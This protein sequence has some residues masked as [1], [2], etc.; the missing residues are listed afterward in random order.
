[1][2]KLAWNC[3][4]R[5][6]VVL[7]MACCML[8]LP[9]FA[10]A[11]I[12]V[13]GSTPNNVTVEPGATIP[14]TVQVLLTDNTNWNSTDWKISTGL[15]TGTY[16][17]VNTPDFTNNGTYTNSLNLTAPTAAGT[18]NI[19]FRASYTIF[20]T[21]LFSGDSEPFQGGT[22]T[23]PDVSVVSIN[24]AASSPTA[25][26]TV[27]WTVTF[28]RAVTGVDAAD[29]ALANTGMTGASIASVTGSGTTWTVT[30]NSGNG[31]GTLGLNLTDDDSI[32]DTSASANRLGGTGP[33]NGNFTGQIYTIERTPPT[34]VSIVRNDANPTAAPNVTWTV[35][36]SESVTGVNTTDFILAN[37]GLTNPTVSS[38]TGS[39]TTWTV[40]ASTGTGSGTLGLNLRD[41]DS[42]VDSFGNP[43]GGTN[44]NNGNFTGQVYT[45]DRAAPAVVSI[46]RNDANPTGAASVA[47]TVNFNESVTGVDE[48][49]FALAITGLASPA[50]TN[51]TVA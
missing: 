48:A 49:D 38:A 6:F 43:L 24:R 12:S 41:D 29:F 39:G 19:Y 4:E 28:N 21:C 32:R 47:W 44:I 5:F 46:L 23:V 13:V 18:Y 33:G 22:V 50:I 11:A 31:S 36:F 8:L 27:S 14:A 45:V 9:H 7:A 30:A 35:T 3:L 16:A 1:M 10:H 42:I 15:N 17:C 51:V 37:T 20:I 2:N 34:V 26:P 40:M 25:A